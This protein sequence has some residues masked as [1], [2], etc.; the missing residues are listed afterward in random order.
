[1][2]DAASIGQP[3]LLLEEPLLEAQL[4]EQSFGLSVHPGGQIV[5]PQPPSVHMHGSPTIGGV[6]PG[7]LNIP[8]VLKVPGPPNPPG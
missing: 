8:G 5:A 1:M 3:E 4:H 2:Q 7:S 6:D